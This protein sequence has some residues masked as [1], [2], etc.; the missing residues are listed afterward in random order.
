[1]KKYLSIYLTIVLIISISCNTYCLPND[2]DVYCHSP[3]VVSTKRFKDV[4]EILLYTDDYAI[5]TYWHLGSTIKF[6]SFP[7]KD[8][9]GRTVNEIEWLVLAKGDGRMLLLSKD[10]L[11][12]FP[13]MSDTDVNCNFI[14]SSL[15]NYLNTVFYNAAFTDNDKSYI[16]DYTPTLSKVFIL[17]EYELKLYCGLNVTVELER[18]F[19]PK[20]QDVQKPIKGFYTFA[21]TK[22][23]VDVEDEYNLDCAIYNEPYWVRT[24]GNSDTKAKRIC[25]GKITL[26]N[27]KK[28]DGIRPAIWVTYNEEGQ[29]KYDE[30][31]KTAIDFVSDKIFGAMFNPFGFPGDIISDGVSPD[32]W[33]DVAMADYIGYTISGWVSDIFYKNGE[34]V[35]NDFVK[36]DKDWYYVD[37][38]GKS[39]KDEMIDYK[40]DKYY[41]DIDGKMVKEKWINNKYYFDKEGKMLKSTTTPDGFLVD[42]NGLVQNNKNFDYKL[43]LDIAVKKAGSMYVIYIKS[44]KKGSD[45]DKLGLSV[46]DIFVTEDGKDIKQ[47]ISDTYIE[48]INDGE[49]IGLNGDQMKVYKKYQEEL[50]NKTFTNHFKD[51]K[52]EESIGFENKKGER[53]TYTKKEIIKILSE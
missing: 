19:Y 25:D 46:G 28:N 10:V 53:K 17:S 14:H 50:V 45:A 34:V 27:A 2:L 12:Q 22:D 52:F 49:K 4:F 24:E 9:Y 37:E 11:F 35:K 36:W 40:G 42:E 1:M 21:S 16:L 26:K 43:N 15:S 30:I 44:V 39:I 13:Y 3:L 18:D 47:Y 33:Y 51:M 31:T 6:G 5:N 29:K 32:S 20:Y 48:I 23:D 8:A 41:L 38:N 7:H